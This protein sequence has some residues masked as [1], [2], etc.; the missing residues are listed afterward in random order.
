MSRGTDRRF[1]V[2]VQQL[3]GGSTLRRHSVTATKPVP[4]IHTTTTRVI[5]APRASIPIDPPDDTIRIVS[6]LLQEDHYQAVQLQQYDQGILGGEEDHHLI[7][8]LELYQYVHSERQER[9][10]LHDDRRHDTPHFR[11][12]THDIHPR[13]KIGCSQ[14]SLPGFSHRQT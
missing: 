14:P 5:P 13:L 12:A 7:K 9:T 11:L 10:I 4:V 1:K 6:R 8:R 3:V 2:K